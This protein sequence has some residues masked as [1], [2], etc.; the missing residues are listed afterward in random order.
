MNVVKQDID[1]L[2]AT[3]TV[4]IEKQDY[5]KNVENALRDYGKKAS[6]NG[7][8]PGKVPAGLVK[9]MYGKHFIVE[10]VNKLISKALQEYISEQKLDILGEPLPI[11]SDV[12]FDTQTD[13]KFNFEIGLAPKISVPTDLLKKVTYNQITVPADVVDGQVE[14]L[15]NRFGQ[16]ID[17]D[18][19]TSEEMLQGSFDQVDASGAVIEGGHSVQVASILLKVQKSEALK[20]LFIGKKVGDAVVFNPSKV[21]E[22]ESDYAYMLRLTKDDTEK[23]SADYKFTINK[24]QLFK[25]AEINQELLDKVFGEGKLK[26]ED[27]LRQELTKTVEARYAINSDYKYLLDIREAVKDYSFDLPEAF[28]KRWLIAANEERNV[29]PEQIEEEFPTYMVDFRWQLIKT[30]IVSNN[31][32][33]VT[34][35]DIFEGARRF[36]RL[37][38]SQ[39]GYHNPEEEDV[40][41]WAGEIVK[42]RE[43]VQRLLENEV[44][45]KLVACL[46]EQ[47]KPTT[48][49]LTPVEFEELFK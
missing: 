7:F 38:M 11:A 4:S 37:Q 49:S 47:L 29:S 23:L 15:L 42:D 35:E 20:Q 26:T 14:Q 6:I 45:Q 30:S 24:I 17:S 8:R 40:N 3:L 33:K 22:N 39:M 21:M 19:V 36:A 9:K 46:K 16:F 1:Q 18:A 12:N 43:Q 31:D 34:Q 13:F 28:L 2:N 32:I 10:Q 41:R 44:E 27:D 5:E 48:K 25:K